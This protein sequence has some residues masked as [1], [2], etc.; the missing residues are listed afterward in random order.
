VI[1]E[2]G[3]CS[4]CGTHPDEWIPADEQ[5]RENE[6]FMIPPPYE[7]DAVT[8]GGCREREQ[9]E[10]SAW[11]KFDSRP[12]GAHV[13]LLPADPSMYIPEMFTGPSKLDAELAEE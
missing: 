9:F 8:C 6:P 4:S 11:P 3:R 2:R 13:A 10:K 5:I 7:A 12:P 1:Y